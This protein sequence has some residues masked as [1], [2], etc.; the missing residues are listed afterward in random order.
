M[1]TV[2]FDTLK[3]V[4]TLE[5]GG[6]ERIQ[7]EGVALAF[8]DAFIEQRAVRDR[9]LRLDTVKAQADFVTLN[10]LLGLNVCGVA[11]LVLRAFS[12]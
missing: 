2:T 1:C 8:R 10:W 7:A 5:A 12:S 9:Q 4:K 3:F 11:I 6:F